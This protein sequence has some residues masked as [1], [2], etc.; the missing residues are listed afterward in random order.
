MNYKK[1]LLTLALTGAT[2]INA[3]GT[4]ND[5]LA[6]DRTANVGTSFSHASSPTGLE[7]DKDPFANPDVDKII[8]STATTG[9]DSGLARTS[10]AFRLKP[11]TAANNGTNTDAPTSGAAVVGSAG[12]QPSTTGD[13][14]SDDG[15]GKPEFSSVE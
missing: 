14:D 5:S 11:G 7:V 4:T 12:T 15:M 3:S 13:D 6:K 10:T 2:T 8:G 9:T 1:F